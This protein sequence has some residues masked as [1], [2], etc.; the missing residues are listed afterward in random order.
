MKL[1]KALALLLSLA[2]LFSLATVAVAADT[3]Q[4]EALDRWTENGVLDG[5][6]ADVGESISR[7][8]SSIVYANLF[9]LTELGDLS[10]FTDID[11]NAPYYEAMQKCY[12]AGIFIGNG[13]GTMTPDNDLN[14][15]QFFTTFARG[16]GLREAA[17]AENEFDDQDKIA[18]WA[19]GS[20]NALAN[21]GYVKGMGDGTVAP[22]RT[23]TV[24]NLVYLLDQ[25]I[26]GYA[27]EAGAAVEGTGDGRMTVIAAPDV[28]V[29]GEAGDL[30]V[31]EGAADGSLTL[32]DATVDTLTV[33]ASADLVLDGETSIEAIEV[34]NGAE[35]AT[36]SVAADAEIGSVTNAAEGVT[37]SGEGAVAEVTSSEAIE[38]TTPNTAVTTE[39]TEEIDGGTKTTT[40][41]YTNDEAG[42]KGDVTTVTATET[43][44]EEGTATKTTETEVAKTDGSSTKTVE[45]ET[46]AADGSTSKTTATEEIAAD[47]SSTKTTA[48][49]ETAADGSTKTTTETEAVAADGTSTKTTETEETA[50]DGSRVKTTET[51]TTDADGVT[52]TT[53]ETT[54]TDA[55]GNTET[56]TETTKTD[57]EGN[58]V[59]DD[60]G[61]SGSSGGSS[62]GGSSSGSTTPDDDDDEPATV[63]VKSVAITE[64][65]DVGINGYGLHYYDAADLYALYLYADADSTY[66]L[67]WTV[68]PSN[69]TN[70]NVTWTS[71]DTSVVE[72]SSTGL[73]T[74]KGKDGCA[75]VTVKTASD[76]KTAT[77]RVYTLI[78]A[79][80]TFINSTNEN[81]KYEAEAFSQAILWY[82]DDPTGEFIADAFGIT[83]TPPAEGA[84]FAG[85]ADENNN[86]VYVDTEAFEK[87]ILPD[88]NF[89]PR[90]F[91]AIWTEAEPTTVAVTGITLDKTTLELV[92]DGEAGVTD[93][94]TL[95]ATIAPENA[96][97]KGIVWSTSDNTIASVDSQG[98][99]HAGGPGTAT[100]TATAKDNPE[101]KATCTVTVSA[102]AHTHT[103]GAATYTWA[104][105]N[106]EC[107]ASHTCTVDGCGYEETETVAAT[108]DTTP[109]TCKAAGSTV[110]TS[111]AFT[112]A[113]FEVQTKT[114]EIPIDA[115]AHSWGNWTVT[116]PATEDAEGVETRVCANDP[117]HT[118]T[119]AIPKL[120]HTHT[121]TAHAA[122]PATCTAAGTEAYW[123]C[124]GCHR[125]F[126]DAQGTNEIQEPVAIAKLAHTLTEHAVAEKTCTTAGNSTAYWECSVCHK[127]FSDAQGTS[128]ITADTVA[129]YVIPAGHTLTSHPAVAK[130]CTTAGNS[131][132]YYEC[133]VCHKYF[134]DAQGTTEISADT[135]AGY[136]I[137]AGHNYEGVAYS[138]NDSDHWKECSACH[139]DSDHEAHTWGDWGGS[140]A[141][142]TAAG[143]ETRTC[144]VCHAE[145][146]R[147]VDALGHDWG[148]WAV[149]T[150]PTASEAG[151]LT[152]VCQNDN[153]HTE[154]QP[155]A[156][157][158]ARIGIV[159]Y[160]TLAEAIEAAKDGGTVKL[161]ADHS[162]VVSISGSDYNLTLDLNGYNITYA[163]VPL[164]VTGGAKLTI[165]NT[166]TTYTEFSEEHNGIY[167]TRTG[168]TGSG[169]LVAHDPGTEVT[170]RAGYFYGYNGNKT[171]IY[172]YSGAVIT[173]YDCLVNTAAPID[174]GDPPDANKEGKIFYAGAGDE[175][176]SVS[177]PN[178][179]YPGKI[180]VYGGTF[181]G[182]FSNS[183]WGVYVITGGTFDRNVVVTYNNP[184]DGDR[185]PTET[186]TKIGT[187]LFT[188]AVTY[189]YYDHANNVFGPDTT[190]VPAG[191][192]VN[193]NGNGTYSVVA[194][195]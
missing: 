107:T 87:A 21:R 159:S 96:T 73:L 182:R 80:L 180:V 7:G 41:S 179:A 99:V 171:A 50:A 101:I 152:R 40:E 54:T 4:Q 35:G 63:A 133:S 74:I 10:G 28:T 89:S 37:V 191:Y 124:T 114:V 5:I 48:T 79:P 149:T 3:R 27:N 12:A 103:Y 23:M 2:M 58:E 17:E 192:T 138:S 52:T 135:V 45:S 110:Y 102:A 142:C 174:S 88:E 60:A 168:E 172:A 185:H 22:K 55:E 129:G 106:S 14:R 176:S 147:D 187:V 69:A 39:K 130:T 170:I 36:I 166:N 123:E 93:N 184:L 19:E 29:S 119:R 47:G 64:K 91:K 18:S 66:Q 51:A 115:D 118:E 126:S 154:T 8:D 78:P 163:G 113:G 132:A 92:K 11:A 1:S 190:W 15:E 16:V 183:N 104:Q 100:I 148:E 162:G 59:K 139:E 46:T 44:D 97:E 177:F 53:T 157:G 13:D 151:V 49:E 165:V 143:V 65:D 105:D 77:V 56:T 109:A 122:V 161:L 153:D 26:G 20:V 156:A 85:W 155:I 90:T 25:T 189:E 117:S 94:V 32:Q 128:E 70:K 136:V 195:S 42:E 173:I 33:G 111:A 95:V 38:V 158:V 125:L 30:I 144:T 175:R 76:G 82:F 141:T 72:V 120:T 57:A 9:G 169:C 43:V 86:I 186:S 61:S 188:E 164:Y 24:G 67:E 194:T 81:E 150:E 108:S 62:S 6:E 71:S 140:T 127:Y 178:G 131:T 98:E 121:L 116:T 34:T 137:P 75:E 146:T 68:E 160:P 167:D 84:V 145:Q 134:S 83:F 181:N 31:A 112:H 193:D